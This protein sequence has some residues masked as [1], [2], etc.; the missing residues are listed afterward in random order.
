MDSDKDGGGALRQSSK[1]VRSADARAPP[2]RPAGFGPSSATPL[3]CDLGDFMT[4]ACAS[5][6][7]PVHM[8]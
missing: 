6:S 2:P 8:G 3:G 7:F 4:N 1:V 5:I